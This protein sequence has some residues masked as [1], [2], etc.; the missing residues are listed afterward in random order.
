M[1]INKTVNYFRNL[2][3]GTAKKTEIKLYEK[4][5]AVLSDLEE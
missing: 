4:Y 5:I 3:T 1:S 2:V